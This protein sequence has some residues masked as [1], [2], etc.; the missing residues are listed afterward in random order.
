MRKWFIADTH[1]DHDNVVEYDARPFGNAEEMNEEIIKRWN[2]K[3]SPDDLVYHLGDFALSNFEKS[4]EM[5]TRLNGIKVLIRGNHDRSTA[6]CWKMGWNYVNDFGLINIAGNLVILV[7]DPKDIQGWDGYILHG[8]YHR[9]TPYNSC[10]C[11]SC[12]IHDYEP[13]PE[14]RLIQW[15]SGKR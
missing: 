1:F 7:H 11:V 10:F 2:N 15:V 4:K 3:V 14:K 8:H 5:L 12:N 13:V 6:Q 9:Q